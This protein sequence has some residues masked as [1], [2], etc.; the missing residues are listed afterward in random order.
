MGLRFA[1]GSQLPT[2]SITH[3][4]NC[5]LSVKGL[6]TLNQTFL[7]ASDDDRLTTLSPPRQRWPP[8]VNLGSGCAR[9]VLLLLPILIELWYTLLAHLLPSFLHPMK[10]LPGTVAHSETN[11]LCFVS[12]ATAK[13]TMQD[14]GFRNSLNL[15]TAH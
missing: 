4:H 3:A 5:Q 13:S 11:S 6:L 8:N 7:P 10:H 1:L 2:C 9:P 14:S 15:L 12:M